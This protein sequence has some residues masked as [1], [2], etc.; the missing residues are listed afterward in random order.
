M[1]ILNRTAIKSEAK[2][3]ISVNFN[4]LVMF[5]AEI[6]LILYNVF[7][8]S[9]LTLSKEYSWGYE[10]LLTTN[11]YITSVFFLM[12][13]IS[14]LV[15]P[16]FVAI[17]GYYTNCLRTKNFSP[18]YVYQLAVM[19]YIKFIVVSFIKKFFLYLWGLL[20]IIPGIIKYYE[21]LMTEYIICD[22][23]GMDAT[24]A[25]RLS[26]KITKGYKF[27]LFLMQISFIPW[28]ILTGITLGTAIIYVSPYVRT[29]Q[30]MYYENLKRNAIE[31]N[32]A[33]AKD[34]GEY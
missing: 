15:S 7:R 3:I 21:Y 19:D 31:K 33:T 4:W 2:N 29:T 18:G 27:N 20:F 22:N 11:P 6:V 16:I 12:P 17:N 8:S 23:P 30:A 10:K 32:I 1:N 5:F 24:D 28:Y 13:I 14:L 25:I 9:I 34:F 26:R